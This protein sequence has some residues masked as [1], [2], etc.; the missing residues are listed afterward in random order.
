MKKILVVVF[1]IA[2]VFATAASAQTP[3]VA[4]YFDDTYQTMTADCPDA[5]PGTVPDSA[6]VVTHNWNMWV[7][8]I[9]YA[10]AYPPQ[11]FWTGDQIAPGILAIGQSDVTL[12]GIGMTWPLPANGFGSL[13]LQKFFFFWMCE[14]CDGN[15][16]SPITVVP[17]PQSGQVRAVRWPDLAIFQGVGLTSL[18]CP[19]PGIPVEEKTWGGIKALYE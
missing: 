6:Y 18:I 14:G 7:N 3:Y 17:Y 19:S 15:W 4:V 16:D 13:F 5:P 9:E 12:G 10:I 8:A 1:A 2:V 11:I